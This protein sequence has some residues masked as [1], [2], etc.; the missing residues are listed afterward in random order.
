M[1]KNLTR[2]FI[3]DYNTLDPKVLG[4]TDHIRQHYPHGMPILSSSVEL[5]CGNPPVNQGYVE[6][7]FLGA[8]GS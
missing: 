8:K 3:L 1:E 2:I 7:C 6:Y 4:S 5:D